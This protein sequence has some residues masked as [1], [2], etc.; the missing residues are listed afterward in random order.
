MVDMIVNCNDLNWQDAGKAYPPD[1]KIKVLREDEGGKTIILKMPKGFRMEA[2][3][4]IQNE[5]HFILNGQYEINGQIYNEGTY[6]LIKADM[7][8]GPFT[9]QTGAEI[10]VIWN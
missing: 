5:Q 8:H 9:S 6:Q 2:H 10:L 3:T 4:H 7:T 1:T